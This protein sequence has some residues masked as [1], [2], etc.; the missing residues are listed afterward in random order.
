MKNVEQDLVKIREAIDKAKHMR[1]RAEARLEELENQQK[2]LL[3]ELKELG[4]NPDQLEDEIARL[5][6]EIQQ[7]LEETWALIPKELMK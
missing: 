5:E 2:R 1:F 6:R 3:N 7:G 4:V